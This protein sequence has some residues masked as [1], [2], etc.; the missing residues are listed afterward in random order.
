MASFVLSFAGLSGAGEGWCGHRI[1]LSVTAG[2]VISLDPGLGSS[3]KRRQPL[4][5]KF[6]AEAALRMCSHQTANRISSTARAGARA[7]MPLA[8]AKNLLRLRLE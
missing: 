2:I 3:S 7:K 1:G 6:E 5:R 4:S 8:F